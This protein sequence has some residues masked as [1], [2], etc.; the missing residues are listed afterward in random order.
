MSEAH[1]GSFGLHNSFPPPSSL[2]SLKHTQRFASFELE[3]NELHLSCAQ[4]FLQDPQMTLLLN[5][6]FAAK[7]NKLSYLIWPKDRWVETDTNQ[8]VLF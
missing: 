1:D 3:T 4:V 8:V 2:R 5:S 7:L 6:S